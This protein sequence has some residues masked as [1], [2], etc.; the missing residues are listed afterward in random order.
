MWPRWENGRP[1]DPGKIAKTFTVLARGWR[2]TV[3]LHDLRHGSASL[4][5][6]AGIPV[7]IV[8]K[9]LCHGS[10]GLTSDAYSHMLEGV[11]RYAAEAAAALV[12]PASLPPPRSRVHTTLTHRRSWRRWRRANVGTAARWSSF[13]MRSSCWARRWQI[14]AAALT[15]DARW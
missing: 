3:R 1:D 13:C 6:A 10:T 7:E 12:P 9:R 14:Y 8:S 11:G 5:L 2:A 15:T 4:M